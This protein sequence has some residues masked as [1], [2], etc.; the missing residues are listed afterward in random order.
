MSLFGQLYISL[1]IR[2]G[3]LGKFFSHEV[4]SFPP[5]SSEFG[6]FY[7]PAGTTS[8]LMKCLESLKQ[9][10]FPETFDCKV[11]DGAV[12]VHCLP[13]TEIKTFDE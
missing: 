3:N 12:I 5:S 7:I 1:Q 8:E 6:K 4:L 2:D 11:L 9:S 13:S 10:T